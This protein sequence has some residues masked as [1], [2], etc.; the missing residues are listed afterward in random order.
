MVECTLTGLPESFGRLTKLT[1]FRLEYCGLLPE[2]EELWVSYAVDAN[3]QFAT[4]RLRLLLLV[5]LGRRHRALCL[6]PEIWHLFHEALWQSQPERRR[7][8]DD[9]HDLDVDDD[10]DN[11]D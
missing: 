11:D 6:P 3:E 8:F 4:F 1:C 10:D 7:W 9:G 2:S 5:M